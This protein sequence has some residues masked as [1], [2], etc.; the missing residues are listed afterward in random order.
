MK[1][2]DKIFIPKHFV[3]VEYAYLHILNKCLGMNIHTN[4]LYSDMNIHTYTLYISV[5][6]SEYSYLQILL[7]MNIINTY[8]ICI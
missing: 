5:F 4:T 6:Q 7:W 3:M 1:I 2:Q 8:T